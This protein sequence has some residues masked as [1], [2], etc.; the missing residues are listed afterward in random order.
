MDATEVRRA[1]R[2]IVD[3]LL[4]D[5]LTNPRLFGSVAR[6]E[7]REDSDLDLLVTM[8]HPLGLMSIARVERDLSAV[9]GRP[10]D[11]VIDAAIRPDLHDKIMKCGSPVTRSSIQSQVEEVVLEST[12]VGDA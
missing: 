3:R 5:G 1:R 11:L 4:L 2:R 8:T 12:Q 6:G 7:E 9:V 10:V